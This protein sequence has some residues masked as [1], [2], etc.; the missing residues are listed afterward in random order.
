MTAVLSERL[1]AVRPSQT[2]AMAARAAELSAQGRDIVNLSLGE[3]DF[4]TPAHVREA[5]ID[6]IQ[7]GHTRYTA[8]A[9]TRL[10]RETIAAKL[11]ADNGLKFGSEQ[12][13][14]G[15]GA[16]QILFNALLASLNPGDEVVYATPCWTSYPE[17]IRLAGGV[18]VPVDC[19][20]TGFVLTAESLQHAV[21][22]RSKWLLLNSPSNPTGAVYSRDALAD[23]ASVL[24]QHPRLWVMS[25]D[26]YEHLVYDDA[27]F[28]TIAEVAPDLQCRSLTVNGVSKAYAMTGWRIGYGAGPAE[29]I[30]GMNIVQSQSTSHACSISQQAAV[31][32]LCRG[33]A[34]VADFVGQF[35]A[36]RNIVLRKLATIPGFECKTKPLGAF[37]LFPSCAGLIGLESPDGSTITS[38]ADLAE[39]LLESAQVAVMPGSAFCASSYIRISYA[40]SAD[41][42][43][44]AMTRIEQACARLRAPGNTKARAS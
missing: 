18:P 1:A 17:M 6:A 38:D 36:R 32:A 35:S 30:K 8:V 42:L 4:P 39:Y 11:E 29:L 34:A 13:T 7:S 3:P 20:E 40:A 23:L 14:V 2:K 22:P 21:T 37:Y 5:A 33:S 28:T 26:I 10:L 15:C 12:I 41:S 16:K 43:E 25:D 19:T 9:G 31:E 24:R 44:K 27:E